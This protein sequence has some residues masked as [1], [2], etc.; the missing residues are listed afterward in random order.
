ME[1]S[2]LPPPIFQP[3][4]PAP[5]TAIA[6]MVLGIFGFFLC[7]ITS[8]PAIICGHLAL[9]QI[10]HSPNL[11][12][13]K[14]MAVVGL[15]LGYLISLVA[16][17]YL[18]LMAVGFGLLIPQL[19]N[20]QSL[21]DT[22]FALADARPVAIAIRSYALSH[23]NRFPPD[24]ES[25]VN[26]KLITRGDLLRLHD[27]SSSFTGRSGSD[28]AKGWEYIAAG[29]TFQV[30]EQRIVLVSRFQNQNGRRFTMRCDGWGTTEEPPQD[31]RRRPH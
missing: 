5:G 26:A 20:L 21:G 17:A 2:P 10:R 4:R 23:E 3:V 7:G 18:V 28:F 16:A 25:L 9:S 12:A 1:T 8:I 15:C 31:T 6:S 30:N 19:G 22:E 29:Q 11:M 13:G 14:G 24:L 27:S